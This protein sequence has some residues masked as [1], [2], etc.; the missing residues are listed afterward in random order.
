[1]LRGMP[2][3]LRDLDGEYVMENMHDDTSTVLN[4]IVTHMSAIISVLARFV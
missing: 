3:Y 1:M 4:V 2:K